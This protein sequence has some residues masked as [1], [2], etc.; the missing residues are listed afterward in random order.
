MVLEMTGSMLNGSG[1]MRNVL[2]DH[3]PYVLGED[4]CLR[5]CAVPKRKVGESDTSNFRFVPSFLVSDQK[6]NTGS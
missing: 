1:E 2:N 3:R 6:L 4:T 5:I